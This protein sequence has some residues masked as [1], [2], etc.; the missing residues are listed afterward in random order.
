MKN[1]TNLRYFLL[2]SCF[3]VAN[4]AFGAAS[5]SSAAGQRETF[6]PGAYEPGDTPTQLFGNLHLGNKRE[7]ERDP[8]RFENLVR[9]L[10]ASKPET[11]WS[12]VNP[13]ELLTTTVSKTGDPKFVA[14]H[15]TSTRH[16]VR[17]FYRNDLTRIAEIPAGAV[18][19]FPKTDSLHPL[20][21]VATLSWLREHS[22]LLGKMA[23]GALL[24]GDFIPFNLNE[25]LKARDSYEERSVTLA[26]EP[27]LTSWQMK[28]AKPKP[29]RVAPAA[30]KGTFDPGWAVVFH[31]QSTLHELVLKYRNRE[32]GE[33][34]T[35][36]VGK[37]SKVRLE[38]IASEIDPQITVQ[39]KA[40][41]S[42]TVAGWFGGYKEVQ[43]NLAE[44]F[45]DMP[46]ARSTAWTPNT[47]LAR[48]SFEGIAGTSW[49]FETLPAVFDLESFW[50]V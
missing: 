47:L 31:N 11:D 20:V 2:L 25:I 33:E 16:A 28:M 42:E 22:D 8:A 14:I 27:T 37:N 10:K 7:L 30:A 48:L 41:V 38:G 23:E 44:T 1:L 3:T 15:N 50:L 49:N 34:T 46:H 45:K 21:Y 35:V 29:L 36:T 6:A 4:V 18:V 40:A 39:K 9:V 24:Y 32:T 12:E 43:L 19:R 17:L 26:L 5:S 13:I